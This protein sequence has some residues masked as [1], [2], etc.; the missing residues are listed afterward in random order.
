MTEPVEEIS[1]FWSLGS[2]APN[3]YVHHQ[4]LVFFWEM[5][6]TLY[7][8]SMMPENLGAA[9]SLKNSFSTK[10]ARMGSI[11]CILTE[12]YMCHCVHILLDKYITQMFFLLCLFTYNVFPKHNRIQRTNYG[13][14]S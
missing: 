7:L 5:T 8:L 14:N 9:S 12:I 11:V 6:L 10:S 2:K 4:P 3:V 13:K 1:V